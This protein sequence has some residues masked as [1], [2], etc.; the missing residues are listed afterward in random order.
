LTRNF[1][2]QQLEAFAKFIT[3]H[4]GKTS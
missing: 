2:K 1:L 4:G 3:Q